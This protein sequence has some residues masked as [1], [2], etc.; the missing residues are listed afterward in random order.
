MNPPPNSNP[1]DALYPSFVALAAL[2]AYNQL[3]E[4]LNRWQ[5]EPTDEILSDAARYGQ[6]SALETMF[7]GLSRH[8]FHNNPQPDIIQ[9]LRYRYGTPSAQPAVSPAASASSVRLTESRVVRRLDEE[10]TRKPTPADTSIRRAQS[11]DLTKA[12]LSGQRPAAT[13]NP[14]GTSVRKLAPPPPPAAIDPANLKVSA[15][16]RTSS[17][18]VSKLKKV[19]GPASFPWSQK[20]AKPSGPLPTDFDIEEQPMGDDPSST[21]KVIE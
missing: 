1:I 4:L 3:E 14:S 9:A 21:F 11:L 19:G 16:S 6:K 17:P 12:K 18:T 10:S 8:P 5:T 2:H 7:P 13:E 15:A 20:P